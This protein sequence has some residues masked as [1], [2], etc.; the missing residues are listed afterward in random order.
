MT[1]IQRFTRGA[2]AAFAVL[3]LT[4]C[5]QAGTLGSVLGSVLGAGQN[6]LNGVI[7][8][9]DTRGQTVSI[10]QSNGQTVAVAYDNQTR[11]VY[12][13]QTYAVTSLERGDQVTANIQSNGAQGYYTD[14]ITVTQP[15]NAGGTAGGNTGGNTSVQL[16]QGTV[17]T[18]DVNNG[19]F[20]MD[21]SGYGTVTVSLPYNTSSA[22]QTRFRNLRSG[23]AVR[24]YGVWL[25]QSRVELRNFY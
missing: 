3:A 14:L 18:V 4:A 12:N 13:N 16:F 21:V 11:V 7:A 23:D 2:T 5:S 19:W 8:G 17:R 1:M 25:N 22:D 6:Q 10:Q 24:L 20:T 15:V 9:V